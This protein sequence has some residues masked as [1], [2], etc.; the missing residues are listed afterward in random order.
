MM[1]KR[2][3]AVFCMM[4]FLT[5]SASADENLFGYIKGAETLP[6][7]AWEI[8]EI[9]TLRT[10]KGQ[11]DYD[12][13][14]SETEI[15]YGVTDRLSA[16]ASFSMQGID[17]E[18]LIIDGYLP[19]AEDYGI[20]PSGVEAAIK[21]NFLKPAIDP[22]GLAAY[23]ALDYDWLDA[24]S[25]QDKDHLS[26]ELEML[27]QKY[28]FEG[29]LIW[30]G[31]AGIESTYADRD[32]ISDLPPDFDWPTDPE[33]EVEL[34]AGTGLSY[35]FIPNWFIGAETLYETEFETEVGQERWSLFAGPSLHYGG[36][37]FWV[38]FT[39]LFQVVGGGEKYEGQ[40][41]DLHLI[42]K[43]KQEVRLK[44]GFNF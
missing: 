36:S 4:S 43:T 29:Q 20:K 19:K 3:L 12:A 5:V 6:K 38:T 9:A 42:E 15:E 14:D 39:W 11:G 8:Y 25:G 41:E 24:H 37:R 26:L 13:I 10:D 21:Y 30:V 27:L 44:V 31:N 18:G 23:L 32:E 7:G 35:R 22:I 34:K 28:F 33:M 2:F 40:T 16:L 1:M 17:T